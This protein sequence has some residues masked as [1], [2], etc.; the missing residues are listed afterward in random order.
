MPAKIKIISN[1]LSDTVIVR[2]VDPGNADDQ[3]DVQYRAVCF[4]GGPRLLNSFGLALLDKQPE[5]CE[6]ESWCNVGDALKEFQPGDVLLVDPRHG[7]IRVLYRRTSNANTIFL[8]S[9]CN[10]KCIMCPQPPKVEDD[11]EEDL[12]I[13]QIHCIPD[14][15]EELCVTGGEPT[16]KLERLIW[17]LRKISEKNP[18]CHVH[19]LSNARLC[20]DLAL[21]KRIA[22]SGLKCL[23]FGVPLYAATPSVHDYVVQA[24]G[25]FDETISG[26]YNLA[27]QGIGVEIR[28]VLHKQTIPELCRLTDYIYNKFPFV[29]H[30]A[31]MGMEHMGFVKKNW[32][33]LW[34]DPRDFQGDLFKAIRFLHMRGIYC[35][36][37]N[38]PYCIANRGLWP[39]IRDSISDYKVGFRGECEMCAKKG[40]C[41][42]LFYYQ[43]DMMPIR[44]IEK[45]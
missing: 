38:I 32:E 27:S 22:Q 30:V 13:R 44:P 29:F 18:D 7:V 10:S 41:G 45:E 12:L 17:V 33:K 15:V 43:K 26:I 6:F 3:L 8:T 11:V 24:K 31:F 25:A 28:V 37:Y 35:S 21:V 4:G 36:I 23:T 34:I 42:G 14:D 1:N 2:V 16:I 9:N 19:I 20:K 39:F 5:E 40:D